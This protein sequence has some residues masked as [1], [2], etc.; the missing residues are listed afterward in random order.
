MNSMNGDTLGILVSMLTRRELLKLAQVSTE[1]FVSLLLCVN[2]LHIRNVFKVPNESLFRALRPVAA[3][4]DPWRGINAFKSYLA[5]LPGVGTPI[6]FASHGTRSRKLLSE[7]AARF[8]SLT[9]VRAVKSPAAVAEPGT[10]STATGSAF[11]DTLNLNDLMPIVPHL[12]D[13]VLEGI[14]VEGGLS[15]LA[16]PTSSLRRVVMRRCNGVSG[17]IT[18]EIIRL[19]S[20][21]H[22]EHGEDAIEIKGCG[23]FELADDLSDIADITYIDLSGINSL[24]GD[25]AVLANFTSLSVFAAKKTKFAGSIDV[26]KHTPGITCIDI[27][28]TNCIGDIS[29]LASCTSLSFFGACGC[30]GIT[31]DIAVFANFMWLTKFYASETEIIGDISFLANCTSLE[32]FYVVGCRGLTGDVLALVNCTSLSIFLARGTSINGNAEAF[33]QALPSCTLMLS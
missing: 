17:T 14:A 29:V 33:R 22:R 1:I 31:G 23:R 32:T 18:G 8:K 9:L 5:N 6:I 13:L 19:I 16:N 30:P 28:D 26:F 10:L 4:H 15:M 3:F 12:Q 21:I 11:V 25:I 7:V 27:T 24:E 2:D 20:N